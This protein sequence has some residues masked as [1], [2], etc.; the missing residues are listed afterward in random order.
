MIGNARLRVLL[1]RLLSLLPGLCCGE[2]PAE[3]PPRGIEQAD[4]LFA[5]GHFDEAEACYRVLLAEAEDDYHVLL[6]LGEIALLANRLDE[7]ERRLS[8]ARQLRPDEAR[9][10]A[11]LAEAY[12]RR[13][14]FQA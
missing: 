7:A 2:L 13:D 14:D 8:K 12:Y 11:L 6:R 10:M 4:G 5:E 3:E 9:P 1:G